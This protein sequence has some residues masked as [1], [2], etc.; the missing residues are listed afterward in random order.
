MTFRYALAPAA[1]QDVK[2]LL[3]KHEHRVVL[4][5]IA[6]ALPAVLLDPRGVGDSKAGP[7]RGCYGYVLSASGAGYR[8]VYTIEGDAVIVLAVGPHDEAYEDATARFRRR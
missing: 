2:K 1:A 4:D 8:L 7:L 6:A 5:L 3:R